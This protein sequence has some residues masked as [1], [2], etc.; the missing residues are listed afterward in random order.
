MNRPVSAGVIGLLI[1]LLLGLGIPAVLRWRSYAERTRCLNHIRLVA[2]HARDMAQ[3]TQSF[4]PG[5]IGPGQLPPEKRLSW[6]VPLLPALSVDTAG[7]ID[8]TAAWDSDV[9]RPGG[10]V[11]I[12]PVL[13][14]TQADAAT[15]DGSG[16]THF[17]GI[18]GVG[19]DAPTLDRN[20]PRAG[21]FGYGAATPIEAVKDGLSNVVL[22]LETADRIGP[23]IAGGPATIRA[24]NPAQRPHVGAGRRFGGI[25]LGGTNSAFADGSG[26]FLAESIHP[27]VLEM[28]AAMADGT[29][30]IVPEN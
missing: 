16:A 1:V 9:N 5:T 21:I 23:W 2:A 27:T 24:L 13:C 7:R 10:R 17:P 11:I 8:R 14:P 6:V 28:L 3:H 15:A 19:P 26:R 4:P 22:A 20:A 18:A 25:H 12:R 29:S 30:D